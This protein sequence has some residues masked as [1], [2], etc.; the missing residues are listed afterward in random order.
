MSTSMLKTL[1]KI[2]NLHLLSFI[3]F[4]ITLLI[5]GCNK[6]ENNQP[7]PTPSTSNQKQ[8]EPEIEVDGMYSIDNSNIHI[9]LTISGESWTSET[10]MKSGFGAEA[11]AENTEYLSG[12]VK[13]DDLYDESG[14]SKVGSVKNGKASIVIG[15]R[16]VTLDKN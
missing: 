2:G 1:S 8:I 11:D 12:T 9:E 3:I 16:T 13:D 4:S 6:N 14:L 5:V 7:K 15:G 10:T